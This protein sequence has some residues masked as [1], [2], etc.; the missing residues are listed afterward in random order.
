MARIE[1]C[2]SHRVPPVAGRYAGGTLVATTRCIAARCRPR[3]RAPV[4]AS[5]ADIEAAASDLHET[6]DGVRAQA[7]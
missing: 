7:R 1:R 5:Y 2:G 4:G 3:N 6:I